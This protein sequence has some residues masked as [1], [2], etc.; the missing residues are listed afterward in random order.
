MVKR[1]KKKTAY[2]RVM[3][4]KT[5]KKTTKDKAAKETIAVNKKAHWAA[6]KD[7]QKQVDKAWATL[8]NN[9]KKKA[10]PQVL[11]RDKNYLLLLLGECNYMA[12]ECMQLTAK[13]K[14]R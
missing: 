2:K 5:R 1:V 14:K 12:R 7:L 3:R 13:R 4:K 9:V 6:Y 11:L 10:T 8:K